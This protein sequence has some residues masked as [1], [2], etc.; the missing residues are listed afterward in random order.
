MKL[1]NYIGI[2]SYS[3]PKFEI[4]AFQDPCPIPK[5]TKN[6]TDEESVIDVVESLIVKGY[7]VKVY[8]NQRLTFEIEDE[9][10][11]LKEI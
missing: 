6:V 11:N 10:G 1:P 8:M 5:F 2:K 9:D 4:L 7:N 3:E